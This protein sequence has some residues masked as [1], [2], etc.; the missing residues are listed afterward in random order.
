MQYLEM[1]ATFSWLICFSWYGTYGLGGEFEFDP[2]LF[3]VGLLVDVFL[4]P[5]RFGDMTSPKLVYS[6]SGS[7]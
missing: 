4:F 7:G 6:A 2:K 1:V 3:R 5:V